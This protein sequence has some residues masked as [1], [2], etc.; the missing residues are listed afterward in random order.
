MKISYLLASNKNP[1]HVK[2]V[3]DNIY[4]LPKHDFE[5]IV[6][7][8]GNYQDDRALCL[9]DDEGTS[10]VH[11][12]N[13]AYRYSDGDIIIICV[14]DHKIPDNILELPDFFMSDKI[15]QLKFKVA[16]LTHNMG[17]PGKLYFLKEEQKQ[18]NTVWWGL[19]QVFPPEVK[20]IRPY[21]VFHFPAILRETIETYMDGVIFNESFIHHYCDSWLGFYE[22]KI[23]GYRECRDL[24]PNNI[25]FRVI[26]KVNL[27][28]VSNHYDAHDKE[29]MK[30]L[31]EL[32]DQDISYNTKVN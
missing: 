15:Q 14:D 31:I 29:M 27:S 8:K 10:S 21:N 12:F 6:C 28:K 5:V 19:H 9:E 13:K 24:G 1:E 16:N 7:T 4:N 22:E 30:K 18:M 11:A 2:N 17:G 25:W 20:N 23:N 32:S 3:I 26:N